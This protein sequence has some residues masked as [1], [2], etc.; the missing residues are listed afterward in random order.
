M[1]DELRL[2]ANAPS[3]KLSGKS[4]PTA[5]LLS[6]APNTVAN[7][8]LTCCKQVRFLF[9]IRNEYCYDCT[10]GGSGDCECTA[11]HHQE[12]LFN[13]CER[14]MRTV[15]VAVAKAGARVRNGY[16]IAVFILTR[17]NRNVQR[18]EFGVK[19]VFDGVFHNRL[20]RQRRQAKACV[21]RVEFHK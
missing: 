11:A 8:V 9:F 15:T 1:T 18:A 19:S 7:K 10:V 2:G 6:L 12:A 5:C 4:K 13:V 17:F 3:L 20:E 16:L 14:D 21:R